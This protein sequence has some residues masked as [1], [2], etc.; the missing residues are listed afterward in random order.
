MKNDVII[1]LDFSNKEETIHFINKFDTNLFVKVGMEL[2]YKEGTSIIQEIKSRGHKVFLDLKL[3]DIPT[4][5]YKAMKNISKLD[6]DMVN[7]HALG[8][9]EMMRQALLGLN[10]G[11]T[12][13]ICIAVTLL[14]SLSQEM[15]EDELLINK[16]IDDAILH[17]AYMTK[18]SGLDGIVCSALETNIVKKTLGAE[19]I[20]V[21]P[22]IRL[23]NDDS[24]DQFRITTPIMAKSLGANYIVVGRSIT[25]SLDPK[26]TYQIIR[27]QFLEWK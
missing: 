22:G 25:K 4:T 9:K 12:R 14:T 6:V 24:N 10:E 21:T 23:E 26:G 17:Y 7:V 20:T 19:F 18:E 2:F 11:I 8:G 5:V 15:V 27:N 16:Q 3:H 1:A 13:P